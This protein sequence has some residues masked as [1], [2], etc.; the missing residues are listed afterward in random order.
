MKPVT[1]KLGIKIKQLRHEKGY[2]LDKLAKITGTSKSYIWDIENNPTRKPSAYTV[3]KISKALGVTV[4][5]LLGDSFLIDDI[6]LKNVFFGKYNL[7]N[8]IDKKRIE[9][10]ID[11]WL[12]E[13][14]KNGR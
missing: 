13:G 12:N 5:Y 2:S 8:D 1:T 11:M 9:Q 10:L 6:V 3:T 4:E 7:L 14:L